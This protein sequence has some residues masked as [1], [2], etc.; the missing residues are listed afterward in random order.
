MISEHG[1]VPIYYPFGQREQVRV[2]N[3]QELKIDSKAY[4][5]CNKI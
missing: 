1:N 4:K 5:T 3:Q 2:I